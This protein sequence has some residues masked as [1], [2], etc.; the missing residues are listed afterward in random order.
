MRC[1]CVQWFKEKTEGEGM[2]RELFERA[3]SDESGMLERE[4]VRAV[5]TEMGMPLT[6][7]ELTD[8]MDA[9]DG[10]GSGEVDF[11]E[12]VAWWRKTISVSTAQ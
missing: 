2:L 8:A 1:C 5:V 6:D 9:M 7:P 4:E 11:E 10:D 12:F 3:D